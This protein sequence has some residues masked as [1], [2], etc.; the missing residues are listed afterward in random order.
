MLDS[1]SVVT[2]DDIIITSGCHNSM[3]LALMAVCK[4]G[5]IVAVESPCYYGFNADAARHGRESD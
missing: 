3:S 5:D 2:A 4:P 1:G